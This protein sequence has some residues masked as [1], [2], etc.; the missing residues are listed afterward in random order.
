LNK[1]CLPSVLFDPSLVSFIDQFAQLIHRLL[2]H[3]ASRFP[4]NDAKLSKFESRSS[5]LSDAFY[6]KN[7][8]LNSLESRVPRRTFI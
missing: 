6:Y 5:S 4:G 7:V 8:K 3:S 1:L 2:H